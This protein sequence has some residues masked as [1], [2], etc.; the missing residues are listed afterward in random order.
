VS[1]LI[2]LL[3]TMGPALIV[4]GGAVAA[5][6]ARNLTGG[7]FEIVVVAPEIDP[8]IRLLPFTTV[9]EARFEPAHLALRQFALVLACTNERAVNAE[10]GRLSSAA[11]IP[12][13]V[14]DAQ[15]ESTFFTPAAVR[16]GDLTLAVST[17]GASPK[18]AREL[19]E[20]IIAALGPAWGRLGWRARLE[21]QDREARRRTALAPEADE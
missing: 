6:K 11:R 10:V 5:R 8:E 20:A 15:G 18:L 21:R 12:V 9:I 7:K 3:P 13:L 17:G 2:E 4:G 1:L 14:A 19:R 16:D